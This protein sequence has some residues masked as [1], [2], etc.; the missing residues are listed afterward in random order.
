MLKINKDWEEILTQYKASNLT[1]RDFCKK[2][3]LSLNQFR[4]RWERL[5]LLKKNQEKAL[6]QE[7]HPIPFFEPVDIKFPSCDPKEVIN[8]TEVSIH[9]PNQIRCDV[10]VDFHTNTFPT[11]L[12]QLM[13]LC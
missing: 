3:E 10:K 9:L 1:Q 5:Y 8:I 2:H 12:K 11:L 7:G 6:I 4:Y 13:M